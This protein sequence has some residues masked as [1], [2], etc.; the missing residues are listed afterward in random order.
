MTGE[1]KIAESAGVEPKRWAVGTL[2]DPDEEM[3]LW[4]ADPPIYVQVANEAD[5]TEFGDADSRAAYATLIEAVRDAETLAKVREAADDLSITDTERWRRITDLL[6]GDPR[7]YP[8]SS[9]LAWGAHLLTS[10]PTPGEP[11][12][13]APV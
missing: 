8:D 2:E 13:E 12:A 11:D 5:D 6:A 3:L 4:P 10:A 9:L 1:R 7:G